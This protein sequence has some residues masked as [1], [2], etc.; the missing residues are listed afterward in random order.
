MSTEIELKNVNTNDNEATPTADSP[1]EN[2]EKQNNEEKSFQDDSMAEKKEKEE[3]PVSEPDG[4][5]NN[6]QVFS[7]EF[8]EF[9]VC[10]QYHEGYCGNGFLD[11]SERHLFG[12]FF[13]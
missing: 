11:H 6:L 13:L 10:H 1:K 2:Y 4:T 5:M 7:I 8:G 3:T 9:L 12:N